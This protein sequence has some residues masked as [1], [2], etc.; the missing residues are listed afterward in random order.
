MKVKHHRGLMKKLE[1]K[2]FIF[3]KKNR[4]REYNIL[5]VFIFFLERKSIFY[6]I[7][8]QKFFLFK[9]H[10]LFYFRVKKYLIILFSFLGL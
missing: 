6:F 3:C 8:D 7:L 1:A 10:I 4:K 5:G 9:N 2:V